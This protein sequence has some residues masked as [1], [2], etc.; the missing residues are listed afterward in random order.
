MF[1]LSSYSK[2]LATDMT[3]ILHIILAVYLE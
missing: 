2:I 1:S 3:N